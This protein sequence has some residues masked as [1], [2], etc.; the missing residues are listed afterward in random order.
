MKGNGICSCHHA[1]ESVLV[2]YAAE[3]CHHSMLNSESSTSLLLEISL[4]QQCPGPDACS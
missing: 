2:Q 3:C 4:Q 1:P